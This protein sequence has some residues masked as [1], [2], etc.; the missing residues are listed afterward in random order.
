MT[1]SLLVSIHLSA[2]V[3]IFFTNKPVILKI[4]L[5]GRQSKQPVW[6]YTNGLAG[7]LQHRL[8]E[9]CFN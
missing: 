9:D 4:S 8:T 1:S 3:C 6:S 5:C 7:Q 2:Q